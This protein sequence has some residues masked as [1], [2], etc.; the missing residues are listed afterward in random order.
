MIGEINLERIGPQRQELRMNGPIA[1]SARSRLEITDCSC[2]D[3]I[4]RVFE[5]VEGKS[6]PQ[7]RDTRKGEA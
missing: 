7:T 2:A 1:D 6:E 3:E 4:G 5:S